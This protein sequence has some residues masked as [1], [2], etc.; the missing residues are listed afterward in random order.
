ML[1]AILAV[2][3][4]APPAQ[5]RVPTDVDAPLTIREWL[6]VEGVDA[7]G[8]RPLRP[9]AAFA[10]HLFRPDSTDPPVEGRRLAGELGA[11][12]WAF[13]S[14]TDVGGPE[15]ASEYA[16]GILQVPES[17]AGVHLAKLSR[18][19]QL[20]VNG[21]P[22]VGDA[23]G[24][25]FAGVPVQLVP[26]ANEVFVTGVRGRFGLEFTAAKGEV[27]IEVR[28]LTRPD[29]VVGE[30][31]SVDVGLVVHRTSSAELAGARV[32]VEGSELEGECALP[33]VEALGTCVVPM[34]VRL[35]DARS[36]SEEGEVRGELVV[37]AADGRE[38]D[39]TRIELKVKSPESRRL[40]S[41][42][43]KIDGSVQVYGEVPPANGASDTRPGLVLSLH[44]A[45]VDPR[46]QIGAYA[47]TDGLWIVAPTNRRPF[48][49]DWQDWGRQDAYEVRDTFV[50][51]NAV[52]PTR[53]YLTGHSMGG[54]GT[55]HLAANDPDQWAVVG[56]SAGWRRFD[57]YGGRPA[58]TLA[59]W[60]H[61]ADAA[62][63]TE[64]AVGN[65][66]Q[67]PTFIVHGDA[68]RN[69]PAEEAR[70]MLELLEARDAIDVRS[71]FEPGKGHW[72]DGHPEPGVAC[73]QWP[74]LFAMF[75]EY[76]LPPGSRQRGQEGTEGSRVW[77]MSLDFRTVDPAVDSRH[78]WVEVLE[79]ETIGRP[80]HVRATLTSG[81]GQILID[82]DNV[83]RLR[84]DADLGY[85]EAVLDGTTLA[86][87]GSGSFEFER[88][89]DSWAVAR[90]PVDP[91]RRRPG[92]SGPFKR[93]FDR[94]FV[95]VRGTAGSPEET[96]A[97][98]DLSRYHAAEWW[99]RANGRA[100][101]MTDIEFLARPDLAHKN[102]I[103]YGNA[104]TNAAW[105]AVLEAD[106]PIVAQ[107]GG[108]RLSGTFLRGVDRAAQFVHRR[109][110][111][112]EALVG[113]FADGGVEGTRL[114][115][116]TAPFVSGVGIPDYLIFD[117]SVLERGDDGSIVTGFWDHD[118]AFDRTNQVGF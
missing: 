86:L 111:S 63:N 90:R 58:G 2:C 47:P 11:S 19:W 96:A 45:S 38:L 61:R 44:G 85:P 37:R 32:T 109:K 60:W 46:A 75:E 116:T 89:G 115:M 117:S 15:A 91:K 114:H 10:E 78:H 40:R 51:R 49:F 110:G 21:R 103:L 41:F 64:A 98:L 72:W 22:L 53:R 113:V 35:A 43:S 6:V 59:E 95:L 54:H 33:R 9:D 57:T 108:I 83:G 84:I 4:L 67:L 48:G 70:A 68:D 24:Y 1:T 99:Y 3:L 77:P 52:S 5:D 112:S 39:R 100:V 87:N 93:A 18:A 104:S 20:Y 7:R 17:Q 14:S 50:S 42:R 29:L 28:D 34:T 8:R 69:V 118:W 106:C 13:S 73:V 71:H 55:W 74:G 23:Y 36:T 66:R 30:A 12:A 81:I 92:R 56:P 31:S 82:T 26:G 94:E 27:S 62:S 16:Y 76:E 79:A 97:L 107:R 88:R 102:V 101:S 25:G 105:T 80:S 65:L